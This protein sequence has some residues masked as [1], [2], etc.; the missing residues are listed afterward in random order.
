MSWFWDGTVTPVS[1]LSQCL[2]RSHV[3]P[4]QMHT[5]QQS[6]VTPAVGHDPCVFL[7]R[8]IREAYESTKKLPTSVVKM[9][10]ISPAAKAIHN[11][12]IQTLNSSEL[13]KKEL[14]REMAKV[15]DRLVDTGQL[16][17]TSGVEMKT[18]QLGGLDVGG[19][20]LFHTQG[21]ARHPRWILRIAWLEIAGT[22]LMWGLACFFLWRAKGK[23]PG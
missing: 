23:S 22:F 11:Y 5:R 13:A 4:S 10:R 7:Q 8:N 9:L 1:R 14:Y 20:V 16:E 6:V 3:R 19:R 18:S 21:Q 15:S 2:Y 17:G 12:S